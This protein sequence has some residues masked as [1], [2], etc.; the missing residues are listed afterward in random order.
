MKVL[1]TNMA[2]VGGE[3]ITS[4]DPETEE[5]TFIFEMTEVIKFSV[6]ELQS[7]LAAFP[8]VR[9]GPQRI[10]YT[11]PP[12]RFV[13]YQASSPNR[14]VSASSEAAL[15]TIPTDGELSYLSRIMNL[16][17]FDKKDEQDFTEFMPYVGIDFN[18]NKGTLTVEPPESNKKYVI[19]VQEVT[20]TN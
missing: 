7:G 10:S 9:R 2:P 3:V 20:V 4:F 11:K 19:R 12:P 17:I 6:D 15:P 16:L 1:L 5:I 14:Q 8:F 18:P 13:D